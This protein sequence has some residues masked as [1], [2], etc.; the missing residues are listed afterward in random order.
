MFTV[1]SREVEGRTG[2]I[3]DAA[4]QIF[5]LIECPA[6]EAGNYVFVRLGADGGKL[7]LGMGRAPTSEP[8]LNLAVIRRRGATLG[9]NEV[10]LIGA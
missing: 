5:S 6:I 4:P 7:L 8:S 2:L 3:R 10:H 9:A 1:V